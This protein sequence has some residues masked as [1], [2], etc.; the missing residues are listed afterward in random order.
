MTQSQA[1]DILKTGA[2]VFLTGEPGSGKT[3]TIRAY[4]EYLRSFGIT[5]AIT[6]STGIAATHI[7]GQTIHSWS[8]IGVRSFL[9]AYDLDALATKEPLVRRIRQTTT[10]IIDEVSMLSAEL[11]DMVDLV[12]R[13]IR[14]NT[15]AFGGI[16]VIL[17]G[18]FFQ[19]PPISG[20][21]SHHGGAAAHFAYESASW[22]RANLVTC[23]L[24]EQH[25]QEDSELLELL[26]AIRSASVD[27][28]HHEHLASRIVS[29]H[30]QSAHNHNEH[31]TRLFTKNIAV[32][33]LN[34][35][36]LAKI[37]GK[38][39]VFAMETHGSKTLIE[40]IKKGCLS[41]ERLVLKKNAVVMCTKNNMATGFVNGT[42]GVVTDFEGGSD[43]P[44]ITTYSGETMT[45]SP[46]D[47]TIEEDGK[48]RAQVTQIP[49]RLAWAMTVHKS[50]GMSL[51]GAVIDLRDVFEYGQGYVALSRV[52]QLRGLFLLGY[53]QQALMVHPKIAEVDRVFRES[54]KGAERSFGGVE[55]DE[56]ERM[57]E[58]FIRASGGSRDLGKELAKKS[59]AK[60]GKGNG[61]GNGQPK[62][63]TYEE[64]LGLLMEGKSIEEI[65]QVRSLTSGTIIDHIDEL[66]R[67]NRLSVD[68]VVA[69]IP[70]ATKKIIPLIHTAF[71]KLGSEKL[72]PIFKQ[73]KGKYSYDD[74][75][76][77]RALYKKL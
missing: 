34:D 35:A 15:E 68:D 43:Y 44:I 63:T 71:D 48:I 2:N 67:S 55:S 9:S 29:A 59:S 72:T 12:C 69:R 30:D 1:L 49:L 41:P 26:G 75:R 40:S 53:N 76:L 4:V 13:T 74:I 39:H 38:E 77:A 58:N 65:A 45:I 70:A 36:M 37:P 61:K 20:G 7:H 50:Q 21:A 8:G 27:T 10:L 31:I 62:K 46:M 60:D 5:P 17:V 56:L 42:L 73:F 22:K 23:Y 52:R 47:W 6:A 57:H 3:H 11:L 28:L 16:Q 18:D 51:D 24:S 19:L 66:L 54:S 32:D 33:A 64:T 25:R 14:Q